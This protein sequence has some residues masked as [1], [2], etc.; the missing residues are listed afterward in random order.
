M[1]GAEI[2]ARSSTSERKQ[3]I[4]Q[5]NANILY[6]LKKKGGGGGTKHCLQYALF[7]STIAL[8]HNQQIISAFMLIC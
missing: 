6:K 2:P 7:F 8:Y 4:I 3:L 5:L 1:T